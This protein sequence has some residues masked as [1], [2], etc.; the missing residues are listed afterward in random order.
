MIV[1]GYNVIHAWRLDTKNLGHARADLLHILDDYAGYSGEDITVVFDGYQVNSPM[2]ETKHGLITV[3]FT[4]YGVT[5]DTHIQ[6]MV[7][8]SRK[9]VK[10]VTADYL[11]QLSVFEAGAARM[12]PSELKLYIDAAREKHVDLIHRTSLSGR[13]LKKRLN[14]DAIS[15][16]K[17]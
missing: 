12:T 14:L 11:E 17:P 9:R 13:A 16:N 4:A 7:K 6:R 8:Q 10:V 15:K 1:D 5:A 3:I 2:S